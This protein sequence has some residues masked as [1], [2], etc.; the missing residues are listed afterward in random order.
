MTVLEIIKSHPR[1]DLFGLGAFTGLIVHHGFFKHGEWHVHTPTIVVSHAV[2]FAC[3]WTLSIYTGT[4][5]YILPSLGYLTI[6]FTSIIL[7]RSFFN[8]LSHTAIPGPWYAQV[9]KLWHVW[10][11]RK[12]KNYLVLDSLHKTYGDFV[13][14]GPTEVTVFHPDVFWTIDG[15]KTDCIKSEWYDILHP[16]FSLVTSRVK[17]RHAKRRRQWN[18]GFSTKAVAQYEEKILKYI[19]ELDACIE[20]DARA[21][22][23]SDVTNLFFWFG[24]DAMGDFVFNKSFG[25]LRTQEWHHIIILLQRA[26][27]LLGPFSPVP[28]LVQLAFHLLPRF[29]VLKDWFD[30][31]DWCERQM[32]ERIGVRNQKCHLAITFH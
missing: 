27:S 20:G 14:T 1:L 29:W 26:L 6:L 2:V 10:A 22:K 5:N 4:L 31:V 13:R 32:K 19:D 9:S 17:S 30:M 8:R 25:M 28:W 15:P 16:N 21:H 7:Y 11:A 3:S 12:S 24:F 18:Q 23:V